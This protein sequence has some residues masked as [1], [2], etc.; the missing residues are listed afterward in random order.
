MG[1][2]TELALYHKTVEYHLKHRYLSRVSQYH[3]RVRELRTALLMAI[4]Y[5][6][7][8]G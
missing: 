5:Y 6:Q 7:T 8:Q 2:H 3:N 4:T 1:L